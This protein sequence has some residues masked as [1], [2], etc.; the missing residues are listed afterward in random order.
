[1][2][3]LNTVQKKL[4]GEAGRLREEG[5]EYVGQDGRHYGI[6]FQRV[7]LVNEM[8]KCTESVHFCNLKMLELKNKKRYS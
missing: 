3:C 4:F 5:K 8:K 7:N 1:M 2:I 6:P